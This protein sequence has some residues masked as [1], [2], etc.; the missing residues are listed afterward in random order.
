MKRFHWGLLALAIV[1]CVVAA[2]IIYVPGPTAF[3][4]GSTVALG[5]YK[6]TNPTGVPV[7]LAS[8]DIVK[9]GEYLTRA[10]DC[11]ACHTAKGGVPYAGGLAF[12]LP[13]GT[14]YSPNITPDKETGIGNWTDAD[15]IN[16]LH[17]GIAPDGSRFYPAFPYPSYTLL[18]N[19]DVL[20][21][22][23]YLFSLKP[24]RQETEPNSL[25]FPFNQ[26]WGMMFW[27]LFYN[28][29]ERYR[30]N[31]SQSA[32]WNRGAYLAEALGHCGECHTPRNLLQAV[33]NKKKFAGAVT[34][35]WR[36]YN[37]TQDATSGI[38]SWDLDTTAKFLAHGHVEGLGT[39]SG[40]MG[41]A[42]DM[43][44]RHMAPEDIN[45]LVVY[46]KSIPAIADTSLPL[47]KTMLASGFPTNQEI[48]ENARGAMIFAGACAACH[49]WSGK[50]PILSYADFVGGRTVNDPTARNVA[51]AII[52]GVTRHTPN[53]VV[54]M[55][56]FGKA[57][58]DEEI[59]AVSNYITARFG[60][61]KSRITAA[62]IKTI[63]KQASQ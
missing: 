23:A 20:A 63:G 39:A 34:A 4:S 9:R 22:K 2:W 49:G 12:N 42:I 53:G 36:A 38:G 45:A 24:V 32:E 50:S 51:Q 25:A 37:I 29:N 11:E 3:A 48:A 7:S 31:P 1:A 35:G 60:A 28:S 52:W 56:G 57:Y 5:D 27:S 30:P 13:F 40:P 15:F 14:L 46:L 19:D 10:A 61:E 26:R 55:P 44:L 16:A 62:D 8:G 6:G 43:S 54:T 21:I 18:T 17:K 58:S 33:D 47:P 59:A 41:E